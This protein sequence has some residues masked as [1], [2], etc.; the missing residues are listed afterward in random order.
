[1]FK[2]FNKLKNKKGFTLI[3]LI[4]VIAILGILAVIAIPRFSGFTER[5]KVGND[6]QYAALVANSALVIIS[7]GDA[8]IDPDESSVSITLGD[9]DGNPTIIGISN[10][11]YPNTDYKESDFIKEIESMVAFKTLESDTYSDGITVTFK[12][13]GTKTYEAVDGN[14][15]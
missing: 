15:G 2:W 5:A 1:M 14:D 7:S 9:D 11:I 3:E 12:D 8:K 13:D 4:V 6:E 10:L